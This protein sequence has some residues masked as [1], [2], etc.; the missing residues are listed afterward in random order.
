MSNLHRMYQICPT[1]CLGCNGPE[2]TNYFSLTMSVERFA[3]A[4]SQEF[5][6]KRLAFPPPI[7][8]LFHERLVVENKRKITK[9]S[10][11]AVIIELS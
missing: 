8:F 5:S 3:L 2:M 11:L 6:L 7:S 4:K 9:C 10:A 1:L